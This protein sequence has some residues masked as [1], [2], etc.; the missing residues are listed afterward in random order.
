MMASFYPK[1]RGVGVVKLK[2]I[3][4]HCD[5]LL[6]SG[7]Y[8]D[9]APNGL[10]LEGR[11]DIQRIVSGVTA[12]QALIDAAIE[13]KADLL[14]VHHGFFWKSEPDVI[15]GIKKRRIK[16]LLD[17]DISLVAY[18]LPLDG[19]EL[20]GNNAQLAKLWNVDVAGRFGD[21]PNG[22][23]A[24]YA[25][26]EN[27]VSVD[28]F[29]NMVAESL[30]RDVELFSGSSYEIKRF[31]WCSG[32]AQGYIQQAAELGADLFISGE[33]SESTFHLAQE[34]GIYYLAC[35]H[36]ATERLG[37]QAL[38]EVLAEKFELDHQFIDIYNPV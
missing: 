34:E 27:A 22:G 3:V 12:S 31:A 2:Q 6:E 5:Q 24:M 17:H 23:L 21:G 4:E 28:T 38:G 29:K 14:L 18:H 10:Q 33:V 25:D 13:H 1:A 11:E 8:R 19:H 30:N 9:Y 32:A 15:T 7:L 35:G 16:A 26:L 36:H 37:V 20:V